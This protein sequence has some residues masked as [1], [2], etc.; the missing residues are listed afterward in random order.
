MRA[1]SDDPTL[2]AAARLIGRRAVE[3]WFDDAQGVPLSP[4]VVTRVG[5]EA[6]P[7]FADVL[8]QTVSALLRRVPLLRVA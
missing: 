6:K 8:E 5:V 1:F 4:Q 7:S 3:I 2:H